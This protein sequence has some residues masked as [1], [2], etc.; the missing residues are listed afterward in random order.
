[1]RNRLIPLLLLLCAGSV[2]AQTNKESPSL[3]IAGGTVVDGTGA[4]GRRAD[5]RITG[6]VITEIGSLAPKQGERVIDARGRVVAPGFIDTHSHADGGLLE[7]PDAETQIRQGITTAI[8]GQDGGSRVP[9]A[10][11]FDEIRAKRAALNIAS[12]VG[13]GAIRRQVLGANY[14]RAATPQEVL[15]MRALVGQEMRAGALGLSTG[16]EY[17]PGLYATTEEVIACAKV[18]ATYGGSYISHVRDE[19]NEAVESFREVIRIAEAARLPAQISHIKLGSAPVWGKASEVVRLMDEARGRGLGITADVYPYT[20]WQS[21]ITVIIP[22]R[23]WDDRAAWERGLAE[24]GGP[25]NVLLTTYT[26]D[27]AWQGKTI[28]RIADAANKD[29]VTILQE[30]VIKTR[31]DRAARRE[32]VVVTAMREEDL[33]RFIAAPRIMFCTDGGLRG[34]HPRGAG[35]YPRILGRYVREQRVIPLEEAVRKMTSLP[36]Q[37]MGLSDRG[38]L[39]PGRKADIVL[40][41]PAT[42]K[43][44]AT[45]ANPTA[46]PVGLSHVLVNGVPVLDAGKMTGARPGAGAAAKITA[47]R[48]TILSGLVMSGPVN[49]PSEKGSRPRGRNSRSAGNVVSCHFFIRFF[50]IGPQLVRA[51]MTLLVVD[52]RHYSV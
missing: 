24:I 5:V 17:D 41:D 21:T 51:V 52:V 45:T 2:T 29:A 48:R 12:F 4:R 20:Y 22:T 46:A 18:A 26:P 9:L 38:V 1:M 23:N 16:L 13:H 44:A 14:K 37:T 36:A 8:V 32:C 15:R 3:L 28:A 35:S 11:F 40:F 27:P 39:R 42:I 25:A 43:D 10:Q 31:G 30:I 6:D 34:S 47:I 50:P 49:D 7:T 33:K 19:E